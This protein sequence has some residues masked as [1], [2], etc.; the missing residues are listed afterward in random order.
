[1]SSG[2]NSFIFAK[3]NRKVNWK[4]FK[5]P[6]FKIP[7][8]KIPMNQNTNRR[9][10]NTNWHIHNTNEGYQNTNW[11]IQN[12]NR[13]IQNTNLVGIMI[14]GILIVGILILSHQGISLRR[15]GY[16]T[17]LYSEKNWLP[18]KG[19]KGPF[20][21]LDGKIAITPIFWVPKMPLRVLESK[22]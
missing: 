13:P 3:F 11:H 16:P 5:I 8:F 21:A 17:C 6:T 22:I 4:G 20:G 10:Q 9:N 15:S 14:I 7:M 2:F 1:M 12:T 19:Q 18:K